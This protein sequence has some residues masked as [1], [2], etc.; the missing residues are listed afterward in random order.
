MDK[1]VKLV[2]LPLDNRPVSY[3]LPKQ[4]AD[5]SGI[6]LILPERKYLGDLNHASDLMCL[7][8]W[9]KD[10]SNIDVL[11]ISL[12]SLVY[13]G[14]VQ[15]RR[16]SFKSEELKSCVDSLN[17]YRKS[18]WP[19]LPVIYGFS[20][21]MRIPNYNNSEQEKDYLKDYGEKVFKWSELTYR[22]GRGILD[23]ESTNEELI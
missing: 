16:H 1:N 2:L 5:F 23:G 6:N 13:G 22:V 21:I 4:I 7:E 15:S 3:L 18:L 11:V 8:K 12:D 9:L 14:L 20:S 19:Q 17:N 10:L